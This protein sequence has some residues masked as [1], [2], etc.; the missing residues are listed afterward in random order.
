MKT[1]SLLLGSAAA[2]FAV[3]GARAA[4][5]IIP[6][7]EMVEY[8]RVCDAAGTGFFYIP[9]TEVC[10]KISGYVQYQMN[11]AENQ[12]YRDDVWEARV[13]FDAW[14]DTEY[15]PLATT[16]RGTASNGAHPVTG[17]TDPLEIDRAHFTIAG[18]RMGL[19]TSAWDFDISGDADSFGAG[20]VTGVIRYTANLGATSVFVSMEND[21]QIGG[22]NNWMPN[23]VVGASGDMGEASYTV[24]L[25]Y[26]ENG[27]LSGLGGGQ[28]DSWH[29]KGMVSFMN[30][31]LQAGYSSDGPTPGSASIAAATGGTWQVAASYDFKATPKLTITPAVA[32]ID[33]IDYQD[34]GSADRWI[35][36]VTGKYQITDTLSVDGR[37]VYTDTAADAVGTYQN[38]ASDG[39]AGRIRF[40]STF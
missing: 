7:P 27:R 6:E 39:W 23:W 40:K 10:L 22:S 5:V 16:I 20:D 2:L 19:D 31:N 12:D 1:K 30:F 13:Q 21:A 35:F 36:A 3:T 8:V 32:Y 9:G 37:V 38:L 34:A 18:L 14:T 15:G 26:D 17:G 25:Y 29:A 28:S 11:F 24:A 4:D 33:D